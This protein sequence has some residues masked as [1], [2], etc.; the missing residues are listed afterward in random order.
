[1]Q[2]SVSPADNTCG[3]INLG[4]QEPAWDMD[5]FGGQARIMGDSI[6]LP[7]GTMVFLNG[8]ATGTAGYCKYE[9]N[10]VGKKSVFMYT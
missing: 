5:D 9:R 8:A 2:S 6:A 1:M 3:R 4:D 7:D 10:E